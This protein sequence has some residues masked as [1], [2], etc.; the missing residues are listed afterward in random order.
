VRGL[1]AKSVAEAARFI[2][3]RG[4]LAEGSRVSVRQTASVFK[5]LSR[6]SSRR[7]LCQLSA[8]SYKKFRKFPT[9][10]ARDNDQR[11]VMTRPVAILVMLFLII[12]A[13][14]D[15]SLWPRP[16]P[17]WTVI[18]IYGVVKPDDFTTFQSYTENVDPDATLVIVTG[19]GG[20]LVGAV[21][22]GARIRVKKLIVGVM[23]KCTSACALIWLGGETGRKFFYQDRP[24]VLTF[25]CFHTSWQRTSQAPSGHMLAA[26][27]DLGNAAIDKYLAALGYNRDMFQWATTADPSHMRC[28]TP[29]LAK[30]FNIDLWYNTEDGQH[31]TLPGK[32]GLL[33]TTSGH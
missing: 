31:Y 11:Q 20:N 33:P 10:G 26:P 17:G 27:S 6:R 16:V 4:V 28:L 1:L 19:P 21:G 32:H 30:K 29:E 8:R 25:L 18:Q 7:K 15:V 24:G 2:V 22:I 3:E 5:S 23:G 12:P 14:A 9:P 13:K